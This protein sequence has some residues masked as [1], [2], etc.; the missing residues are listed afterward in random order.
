MDHPKTKEELI[1][2]QA[3]QIAVLEE[4]NERLKGER[5]KLLRRLAHHRESSPAAGGSVEVE[6]YPGEKMEILVE[7]VR[8]ARYRLLEGSRRADII[9]DFLRGNPTRNLPA[10]KGEKLKKILKGYKVLDAATRSKLEDLGIDIEVT[11]KHYKLRYASLRF[12]QAY[13]ILP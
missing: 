10:Q 11:K 5:D 13:H 6:L 1:E 9:D 4:E 2:R 8:D 3:Q 12:V 7:V